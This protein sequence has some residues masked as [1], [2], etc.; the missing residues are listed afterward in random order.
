MSAMP[1]FTVKLAMEISPEILQQLKEFSLFKD[2]S[3]DEIKLRQVAA[4][5]RRQ[6]AKAGAYILNE[7]EEGDDLYL[8]MKGKVRVIK[9]TKQKEEYTIV[10]LE[11]AYHVFFGEMALMD[12]DRRSASVLVLEDAELLLLSRA[13]FTQLGD[14]FPDIGLPITRIITKILIGR[15][16]N[17]N[18]DVILLF[19]ALVD[20]I[21]TNHL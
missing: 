6:E 10:D 7:G 5:M 3:E 18:N 1:P 13:D 2:F 21:Q 14:K 16:R 15:L 17:V 8:L 11:A 9:H 20:E 4:V 19:D 12:S